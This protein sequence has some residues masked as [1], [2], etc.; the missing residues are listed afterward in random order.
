MDQKTRKE[1]IDS[2]IDQAMA[3]DSGVITVRCR[4][5]DAAI[6]TRFAIYHRLRRRGL[7]ELRLRVM[8]PSVTLT[9][10]PADIIDWTPSTK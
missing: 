8:G 3:L 7:D 9:K 1:Q 6:R 10:R 2:L 5:N 4:D